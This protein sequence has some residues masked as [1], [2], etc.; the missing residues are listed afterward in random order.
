MR[1]DWKIDTGIMLSPRE[2][3][4]WEYCLQE[5]VLQLKYNLFIRWGTSL[6]KNVAIDKYI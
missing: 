5:E 3:S 2:V 4:L 6:N 1:Q